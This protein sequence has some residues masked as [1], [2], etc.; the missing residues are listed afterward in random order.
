M[1]SPLQATT[2]KTLHEM[3]DSMRTKELQLLRCAFQLDLEQNTTDEYQRGIR[4]CQHRLRVIDRVLKAR[5]DEQ[6]IPG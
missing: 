4:F 2:F 3:Y 5:G 1:T 6:G